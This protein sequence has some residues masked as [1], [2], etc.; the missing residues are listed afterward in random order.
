MRA[1][2]VAEAAPIWDE[3]ARDTP[4]DVWIYNNAGIEY[5]SAG[6]HE[7]ALT[8][9]TKG[10]QIGLETNDPERLVDQLTDFRGKSLTATGRE[11]DVLQK[12]A[13]RFL[14]EQER[15]RRGAATTARAVPADVSGAAERAAWA[16]FPADEY[17]EAHTHWPD[18]ADSE[19]MRDADQP[20]THPEYCRRMERRLRA[21][22]A[23]GMRG[24]HVVPIRW[25]EF[26]TW[27]T[28]NPSEEDDPARLRADYAAQL[29]LDRSRV[30][31]WP[32]ARNAPCWCGSGRKYKKCCAAPGPDGSR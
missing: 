28:Q 25:T 16:W 32:P 17:A 2:R 21:A 4:D 26:T 6:D 11:P 31:A 24:I 23:A 27:H 12:H 22:A 15:A 13:A 3:V 8:W 10:L 19:L 7:A 18:L 14:A 29:A 5:A 30:I 1:G 20:V 9:L